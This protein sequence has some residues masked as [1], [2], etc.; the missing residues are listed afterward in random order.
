[1]PSI[2][3]ILAHRLDEIVLALVGDARNTFAAGQV[4]IVAVVTTILR[5]QRA[6]I[7]HAWG[8]ARIRRRL[9]RRQLGKKVGVRAQIVI[10][11]GL[12]YIVHFLDDTLLF[13]E[14]IKLDQRIGCVLPAEQGGF[15]IFRLAFLAVTSQA[16]RN[17]FRKCLGTKRCT[18]GASERHCGGELP[19]ELNRSLHR[20]LEKRRERCGVPSILR[21][22][23]VIFALADR[24]DAEAQFNLG[25]MYMKGQGVAQNYEE[26]VKWYRLAAEQGTAEAQFYLGLMSELGTG[27]AQDFKEAQKWYW[28]AA[29]QGNA[30]A[31]FN[32]GL[33]YAEGKG[34]ALD[35]KEAVKWYRLAAAQ[36]LVPAQNSL[37][38]MYES[39][40]GVAQSY[41]EAVKWYRLAAA[42]GDKRTQF[43]LSRMYAEGQG[44]A[45]DFVRA[46]MWSTIA[47]AQGNAR[48]G[49]FSDV[50]SKWKMTAQQI[51][52][53][54]ALA[55]KCEASSYKHCD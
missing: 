46:H 8:I 10:R 31:Q 20:H 9:R 37:G 45:R 53:A 12:G 14:Q 55:R 54:H 51:A 23:P 21:Q 29:T 28:V 30:R 41:K 35:F 39:G 34:V 19:H 15:W 48:A 4:Q 33:V 43:N 50:M 44:V 16:W 26:A 11:E 2:V 42:Q 47:A 17:S 1:V 7:L 27:V 5:N 3:L 22:R 13:P 24:G 40:Y 49:E 36:G 38:A 32:L 25:L 52:E 18:G 6:A